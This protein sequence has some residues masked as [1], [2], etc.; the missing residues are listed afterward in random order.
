MCLHAPFPVPACPVPACHVQGRTVLVVAHRLSTVKNADSLVGDQGGITTA[1]ALHPQL[2]LMR[3]GLDKP[4]VRL[5][6]K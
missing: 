6:S 2:A 5:A 4:Y 3:A 1:C